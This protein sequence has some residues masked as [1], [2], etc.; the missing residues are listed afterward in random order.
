MISLRTLSLLLA[1]TPSLLP[2]E[3]WPQW[4]GPRL[5]GTSKDTGFPI[6]ADGNV[7]WKVELPGSGHASPIVWQDRI[8]IV[9]A[10]PENEERALLCL[11][12]TSGKQLWQSTILKAPTESIHKLN[13]QASSTPATDGERVFTAFL[14]N[15]ETDV[16]RAI[17]AGKVFG[18]GEVPKGT[19]V[20]S[21]H[22]F[23][24]KQIWQ[25]RPGLFSSKHGFCSSPIVFED[26]V[27]VNCDHD[28]DG[29]IVALARADGKELWRIARPNN[30]RSY[31]VPLIR[32]I[33]GRTQM[34]LSGTLC[35]TSYDPRTGKLLWI[36]D[37][38]TEQFVASIVYSEQTGLLYMTGGFPEHH[39]LAIKPDGSGNVTN[40]HIVWRTNKGVSY[41][42]SPIIE[43]THL[44]NV[45]D[46]GVA[47]CFDAKSG[48]IQWEERMREH[49]ASLTSAEG[50]VFFINDFGI[51][52]TVQPDK[53]YKLLAESELKE[54]VF[55]S[56]ALS[57]GQ[58]FIRTDKS[59]ICLGKRTTKTAAR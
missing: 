13:S 36:I 9:A 8:F 57:E 20:I 4:R 12:R 27:I 51:L 15:T 26:K 2:A 14:D 41:V 3:D 19:V 7:T 5:D 35:V 42:P 44:L 38:P 18:K 40:T 28:G 55:A 52:R 50:H 46:S 56:P 32:D 48:E 53:T 54:K 45:S 59:L 47:H 33:A 29:Y 58:L 31:C 37:G 11:D 23:S 24:G 43:G 39:L 6:S 16:T 17:N 22:D 21:A 10:L 30:T 34:V 25:V 49:H 1:L